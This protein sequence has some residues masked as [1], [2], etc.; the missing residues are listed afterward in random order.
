MKVTNKR[1]FTLIELLVVVL[2]IGI[3]AAVAL[4]QYQNA[5]EKSRIA[6]A[7]AVLENLK[8]ALVLYRY[9][10][11]SLLPVSF[12]ELN[13]KGVM[14]IAEPTVEGF[15]SSKMTYDNTWQMTFKRN[16]G[17]YAECALTLWAYKGDLI[18]KE[19]QCT[20]AKKGFCEMARAFGYKVLIK[21]EDDIGVFNP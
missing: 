9:E 20:E 16:S 18:F 8:Q 4:P 15:D 14:T 10:Y 17:K 3:L 21:T 1:G 7:D 5:V 11:D 19:A 13:G 2:I 6:Q 12:D